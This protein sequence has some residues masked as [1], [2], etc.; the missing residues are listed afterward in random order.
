MIGYV[1]VDPVHRW[2]RTMTCLHIV[3]GGGRVCIARSVRDQVDAGNPESPLGR[4]RAEMD[5]ELKEVRKALDELTKQ[6]AVE[7]LRRRGT[8]PLPAQPGE[9]YCFSLER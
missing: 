2:R 1:D 3:A 6:V 7:H 5:S 8:G 9:R 4:L